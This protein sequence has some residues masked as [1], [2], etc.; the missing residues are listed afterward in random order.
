MLYWWHGCLIRTKINGFET[1]ILPLNY[2]QKTD[3]Q[4]YYEEPI[5]RIDWFKLL[6]NFSY[7]AGTYG[8]A[9]FTDSK[10]KT[11]IH[12]NGNDQSNIDGYVISRYNHFATGFQ[13]DFLQ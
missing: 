12:C 4:L 13:K 9:A 1:A 11:F 2:N 6:N 10:T 7:L 5:G 3:W 8:S